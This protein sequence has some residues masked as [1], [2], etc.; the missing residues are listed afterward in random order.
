MLS[1]KSLTRYTVVVGGLWRG[2]NSILLVRYREL[3]GCLRRVLCQRPVV[4][5]HLLGHNLDHLS[6][7]LPRHRIQ[8]CHGPIVR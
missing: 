7:S 8:S 5:L 1:G 3:L 2:I 6:A 4:R